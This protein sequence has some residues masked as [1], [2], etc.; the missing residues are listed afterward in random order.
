MTHAA[1]IPT[2]V[3]ACRFVLP[4]RRA[5]IRLGITVETDGQAVRRVRLDEADATEADGA[6]LPDGLSE[7]A[8]RLLRR[9]ETWLR[10]WERGEEL[11]SLP[12]LSAEA[13]PFRRAVWEEVS[14]VP[15]G[16]A[17]SYADLARR[18][19]RRL[20]R[21][22]ASPRAVGTALGRNPF[23]LFVPCHRVISASG[24]LGGYSAGQRIKRALLLTEN[25]EFS[26]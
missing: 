13:T 4:L 18:V 17:V 3:V 19:A 2:D 15:R 16:T 23:L 20:N 8:E 7:D 5:D 11:P 25:A 12:P 9:L 14:T 24:S 21:P 1:A 22:A 6:N 26:H 10:A